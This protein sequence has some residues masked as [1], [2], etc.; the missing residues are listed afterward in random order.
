MRLSTELSARAH[1]VHRLFGRRHHA[2]SLPLGC[3]QLTEESVIHVRCP[4]IV[5]IDSE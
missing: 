1:L 4:Q 3:V 5:S 2:R